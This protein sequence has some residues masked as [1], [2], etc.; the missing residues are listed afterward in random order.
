LA[1]AGEMLVHPFEEA[2]TGLEKEL[3]NYEEY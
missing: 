1:T 2:F 3:G